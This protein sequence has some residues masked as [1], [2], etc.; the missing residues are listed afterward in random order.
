MNQITDV[1]SWI[2][3]A[4]QLKSERNLANYLAF[5]LS[6]AGEAIELLDDTQCQAVAHQMELLSK[7]IRS[8]EL[9]EA[10]SKAN[11]AFMM[12]AAFDT[13]WCAIGLMH[14][15]GDARTAW[16]IGSLS[17]YS[18]FVDGKA[19]LTPDGKVIKGPK[20]EAPDFSGVV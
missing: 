17:N 8:G 20:F 5:T 1:I 3:I 16:T 6:E 15:L 2:S 9:D 18:K 12:D 4:N 11:R 10:I 19:V 13:A 14:M 7:R